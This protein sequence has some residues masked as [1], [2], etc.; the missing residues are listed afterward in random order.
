[1]FKYLNVR[2]FNSRRAQRGVATLPTMLL[3]GG[4]IIEIT[5]ALA[6]LAYHFNVITYASRIAAE[7]LEVA[8][9][10]ASEATLRVIRNKNYSSVAPFVLTVNQNPLR[11]ASVQVCKDILCG[12]SSSSGKTEIISTATV[13]N[14]SGRIR[15]LL[16]VDPITGLV[17]VDS[18]QEQSL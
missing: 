14:R 16:S 2:K 11:T 9:A 18:A 3:L 10:G 5:I 6:F 15:V 13:A 17:S 8:R 12:G 4:I 7:V 1:M